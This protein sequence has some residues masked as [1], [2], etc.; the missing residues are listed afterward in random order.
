M[1]GGGRAATVGA[2]NQTHAAGLPPPAG[3]GRKT[4][5]SWQQLHTHSPSWVSPPS[6]VPS[7]AAPRALC[8]LAQ[9]KS[10]QISFLNK[11]SA[12]R[13]A[14]EIKLCSQVGIGKDWAERSQPDPVVS[15][16]VE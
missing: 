4:A 10:P 3:K 13:S 14:K 1:A 12:K 8:N 2:A 15:P 16:D 5:L 7:K 11:T 9:Y 6:S